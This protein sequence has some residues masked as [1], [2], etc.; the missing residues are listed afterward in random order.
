MAKTFSTF[1]IAAGLIALSGTAMAHSSVGFGISIGTPAPVYVAPPPP[2]V[3][4]YPQPVY[5]PPRPV[6]VAPAPVYYYAPPGHWRHHRHHRHH[7]HW[8]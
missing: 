6:Y 7:R 4:Y 2:P 3:V 1:A 8:H 5:V